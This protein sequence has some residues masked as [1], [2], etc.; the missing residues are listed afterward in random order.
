[1]SRRLCTNAMFLLTVAG[2]F[3]GLVMPGQA[4]AQDTNDSPQQIIE[5][6][7][8]EGNV[9]IGTSQVLAKIRSRVGEPF[10]AD[11]AAE[12]AKRIADISGVEYSYYNTRVG[13]AGVQLAFVIIEKNIIRAIEFVGNKAFKNRT[14]T[15]KLGFKV[16]DYLDPVLA[17]TYKSTIVEF[18]RKKGY[19]F[20]EVSLDTEKL[21]AGRVIYT[22]NEGARVKIVSAKFSGNKGIGSSEL[23]KTIK[24]RSRTWLLLGKYYQEDQ[25]GEDL[26]KLQSAYQRR[27]Y[28]N[29][30]ITAKREYNANKTKVKITFAITEGVAYK[31]D[32][33]RF[34]GNREYDEKKL[35]EQL[36]LLP[37]QTYN[38]QKAE[39][40]TKQLTKLYR[41]NGYID[42]QVERTL[43][44]VSPNSVDVEYTATEGE[45]F[46][47]GQVI[48]TGNEQTQDKV[49]RRILDEYDF[50]PGKWYNADI[51]RGDGKGELERNLQR[52]LLTEREGTTITPAGTTPGQKEAQVNVIEGK[53]GMVMLGAGVS[54]DSGVIGQI[55]FEQRN[56]NAANKPKSFTDFITGQAYK[57]AGQSFRIALQPGT[58]MSE[59]S[60]SFSEP[61]LNDKP[62]GLDLVGSSWERWRESYGEGRTKGY[63]GLEKRYKNKWRRSVGVR[64]ENV[65]VMDIDT[66]A[67]QEIYDVEG[68]NFLAGVELGVGK[69]RTNDRFNPSKGDSFH[70]SYEQVGGDH[71]FGILSALYRRYYTLYEDLAE[72]RTILATKLLGATTVAEAP[73]FERFYAGGT[74]TYGIR[75]FEYRGVSTRGLQTHLDPNLTPQRKDPIG[76][77]WILLANAE[78]SVPLI[79]DNFSLFFFADGG[80]IDTGGFRAS[81]GGGIQIMIP[82]WFGPVP[83]TFGLGVPLMKDELDEDQVFFFTVG[84]L[85]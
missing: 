71:M 6:I 7:R 50:Q 82:Q 81:T 11:N 24:T 17:E 19:A 42:A 26:T 22:V 21:A 33:A 32:N 66:D 39:M 56:F 15:G 18:Y 43:K 31:V 16:G 13:A 72:R 44:F 45:R 27:G 38:Q 4:A 55:I 10:D 40:D 25:V 37:G 49:V 57:G 65:K 29:A 67:P 69:D 51:A 8:V 41:E 63:V 61:Y 52:M 60:V 2:L 58:Q 75:G 74:G 1:M 62:V 23:K 78:V 30:D 70:V 85:F 77:D 54:S 3:A 28:L 20:T 68:G 46:R 76:S 35:G 12:D 34:A 5:S 36:T 83:M 84:R 79:G 9:S 14:L 80:A 59:Y 48:I 47:I 73:P 64:A 53:T